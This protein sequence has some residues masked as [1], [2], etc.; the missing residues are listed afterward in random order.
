MGTGEHTKEV[1][2]LN[3]TLYMHENIRDKIKKKKPEYSIGLK[4]S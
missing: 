1:L 4:R 2:W 3:Y